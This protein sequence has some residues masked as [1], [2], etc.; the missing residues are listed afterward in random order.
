VRGTA[1]RLLDH[2]A[3]AGVL[4][5]LVATDLLAGRDSVVLGLL[6]VVPLL[7]ATVLPARATAAYAG[8]ALIAAVLLGVYDRQYDESALPAQ[9]VKLVGVALGGIAAV[10][11]SR[12]RGR[13][14]ARL[15]HVVLVAAAA[16]QALL[17]QIPARV[18]DF[19][20]AT[21]YDSADVDAGVGGDLY[22][23]M[24]TPWGLRVLLGDV[25]GKGLEGV[26]IAARV[27]GTFRAL[28]A[29]RRSGED[30]LAD[31]DRVVELTAGAE[32]FVTAVLL[33][34]SADEV[35]VWNAGH[36]PPLLVRDGEV[37]ALSPDVPQPPLGLLPRPAPQTWRLHADDLL[38]LYTD[39]LV[40][41][42]HPATREFFDLDDAAV[43][44]LRPGDLPGA[45]RRLAD[46][47]AEWTGGL[48]DDVAMVL[49]RPSPPGEDRWLRRR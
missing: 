14:E 16:Q 27:L 47:V 18:G 24:A 36:P 31:L 33:E 5:V 7:A 42:R 35:T 41:A 40:E 23:V 30:V 13:R 21:S 1:R 26:A 39:G 10:L 22:E 17:T 48:S 32:D 28:A 45:L 25:K 6:V 34:I 9:L 3:P 8:V 2:A 37:T 12:V 15:A 46:E 19:E 43:R 49:L 38:L 29:S 11:A 4:G 44:L 20:V